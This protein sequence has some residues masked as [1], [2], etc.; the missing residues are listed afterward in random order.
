LDEE[1]EENFIIP[2]QIFRS[3]TFDLSCDCFS[4][5]APDLQVEP[6]EIIRSMRGQ[7]LR[8]SFRIHP[9]SC[10]RLKNRQRD[11]KTPSEKENL[12]ANTNSNLDSNWVPQ[13]YEF[14]QHDPT[15]AEGR[16]LFGR[17][18]KK[19]L[20]DT[21]YSLEEIPGFGHDRAEKM[22]ASVSTNQIEASL[23]A[24]EEKKTIADGSPTNNDKDS[25][26]TTNINEPDE[27]CVADSKLIVLQPSSSLPEILA[28]EPSSISSSSN[29]NSLISSVNV[30]SGKNVILALDDKIEGRLN[31][32]DGRLDGDKEMCKKNIV[33]NIDPSQ[34]LSNSTLLGVELEE[35]NDVSTSSV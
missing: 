24:I 2:D 1:D 35:L 19:R 29:N 28:R 3:D 15:A 30:S 4:K 31:P 25:V 17:K 27:K 9:S 12:L 20:S 11:S 34:S 8:S 16:G 26:L 18:R 33:L 10:S 23:P 7:P 13:V 21:Y 22:L 14:A 32:I 5:M 6:G